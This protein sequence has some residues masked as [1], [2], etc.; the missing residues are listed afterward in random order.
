MNPQDPEFKFINFKP[1]GIIGTEANHLLGEIRALLPKMS[2]CR[3]VIK[4]DGKGFHFS[5][6]V[7]AGNSALSSDFYLAKEESM[8]RGRMWQLPVLHQMAFDITSQIRSWN[9]ED[10]QII[11]SSVP[12]VQ[13]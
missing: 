1:R 8:K 9:L 4:F 7:S 5:I 10:K 13:S 3:G 11:E 12:S 6:V 2:D